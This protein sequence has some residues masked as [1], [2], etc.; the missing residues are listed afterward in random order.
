MIRL[1]VTLLTGAV[2]G[3]V[4]EALLTSVLPKAPASVRSDFERKATTRAFRK[5]DFPWMTAR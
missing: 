1:L 4:G 5:W 2:L 3:L